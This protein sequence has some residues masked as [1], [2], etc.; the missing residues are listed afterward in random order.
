MVGDAPGDLKAA[1]A[2]GALFYP[3]I[4][5]EEEDSWR[6]FHEEAI[7]RFLAGTYAGDYERE[8]LAAFDAALPSEPPWKR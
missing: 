5:G 1:Q 4:P 8:L 7:K 2:N 6:R 3:V